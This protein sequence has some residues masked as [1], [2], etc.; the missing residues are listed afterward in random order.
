[1]EKDIT[2]KALDPLISSRPDR[3]RGYIRAANRQAI[4]LEVSSAFFIT[5]TL[6]QPDDRG[7]S[8]V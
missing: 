4:Q 7:L 8:G 5:V 1:M 3:D 2:N 6:T